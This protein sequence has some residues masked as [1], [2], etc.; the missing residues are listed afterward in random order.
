MRE[1]LHDCLSSLPAPVVGVTSLAIGADTLFARLVLELGGALEAVVP[2]GDYEDRFAD[3]RDRQDYR[4]LLGRAARVEI[5]Q[6]H[7]TDEEAYYAAGKRVADLSALLILVWDGKPAAGLGGTADIA[8]Y[9][10]QS[11][12]AI[13]HLN[14]EMHTVTR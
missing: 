7:G 13:I 4:S 14:P 3:E 5:L 11:R 12:K 9:V 1:Q 2:F 8:E 6:R 10:R